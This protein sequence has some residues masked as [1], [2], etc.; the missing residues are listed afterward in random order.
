MITRRREAGTRPKKTKDHASMFRLYLVGNLE[1]LKNYEY[2][3][4]HD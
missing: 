3:N 4:P 1:P 2:E